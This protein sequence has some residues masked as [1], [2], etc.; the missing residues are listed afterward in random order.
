MLEVSDTA[1]VKLGELLA[2]DGGP[3]SGVRIAPMGGGTT[4]SG[5]GLIVEEPGPD[6]VVFE[7]DGVV[8]IVD[9]N[10]MEYCKKISIEFQTAQLGDCGG[11]SGT[12]F[13]ITPEEPVNF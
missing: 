1:L 10:L 9:K 6:D 4:S 3:G 2:A 12:G 5:L 7:E 8:L 11:G 13:V